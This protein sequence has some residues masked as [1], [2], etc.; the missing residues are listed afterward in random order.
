MVYIVT[1]ANL[2]L[3]NFS[4]DLLGQYGPSGQAALD[5]MGSGSQKS[6]TGD[7]IIQTR[8]EYLDLASQ[9]RPQEAK[10]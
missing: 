4:L 7:H 1:G 9:S 8:D 6:A 2:G 10:A 5:E 3:S